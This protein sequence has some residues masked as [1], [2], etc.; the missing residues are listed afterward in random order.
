MDGRIYRCAEVFSLFGC[1][2]F[3]ASWGV[4]VVWRM[5]VVWGVGAV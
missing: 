2:D 5:G 3:W 1:G 4:G